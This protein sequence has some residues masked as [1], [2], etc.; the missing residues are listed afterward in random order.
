[1]S[2]H[3]FQAIPGLV[4]GL[5]TCIGSGPVKRQEVWVPGT[6]DLLHPGH[7]HLLR[8]AHTFGSVTVPLNSDDYAASFKRRPIQ[9]YEERAQMLAAC[10]YVD[11]I[12]TNEGAG[13]FPHTLRKLRPNLIMH[14]SDWSG[15]EY[16]KQLE[17]TEKDLDDTGCTILYV[18]RKGTLSTSDLIERCAAH[19]HYVESG[20][21]ILRAGQS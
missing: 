4:G 2:S 7:L 11:E 3:D 9:A 17:I 8:I 6:F 19:Q 13:W 16:L 20:E 14:G 10:R 21:R 1:M 12:M 18:D 5:G 15:P